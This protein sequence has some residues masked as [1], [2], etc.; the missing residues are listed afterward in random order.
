M[1]KPKFYTAVLIEEPDVLKAL[2]PKHEMSMTERMGSE[3]AECPDCKGNQ[4]WLF[5]DECTAVTQGGK[6]YIKCL[7]CG[8]QTHL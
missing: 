4:W 8:Y 1:S 3:D 7:G 6:H 5:P 2:Y